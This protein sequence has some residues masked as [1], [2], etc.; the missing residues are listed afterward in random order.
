ML[1]AGNSYGFSY[2]YNI[3]LYFATQTVLQTVTEYICSTGGS[4]GIVRQTISK[5]KK[6]K[7][8]QKASKS[9]GTLL[10]IC[11][12]PC[13]Q[14]EKRAIQEYSI[15]SFTVQIKFKEY[16]QYHKCAS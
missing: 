7:F 13:E 5:K 9:K 3:N 10:Q 6:K 14:Y 2:N 15:Y 8:T 4:S 16:E 11:L 12:K 1:K